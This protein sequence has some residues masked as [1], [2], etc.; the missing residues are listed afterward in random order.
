MQGV[1]SDLRRSRESSQHPAGLE[2]H[3]V[4]WSVLH[5]QRLLGVVAMVQQ[6]GDLMQPLSERATHG[7]IKFLETAA[8][9]EDRHAWADRARDERQRRRITRGVMQR[10]NAA[11]LAVVPL[12]LDV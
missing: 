7:D 2:C 4:R 8:N 12:R 3:V 1:H 9:A 10:T 5:I 6:A 11:R